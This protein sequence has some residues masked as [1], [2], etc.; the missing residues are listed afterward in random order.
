MPIK[1][2]LVD[3]HASFGESV[4]RALRTE[5]DLEISSCTAI[6]AAL[7][8][9]QRQPID[10]VL[11]DHD[12]GSERASQFL[13]AALRRGFSGRVVVVTAWI[14]DPEARL[15]LRQGVAGIFSKESSLDALVQSI[16]RVHAGEMW[17]DGRYRGLVEPGSAAQRQSGR[18]RALSERLR[19]VLR[20]VLDGLS[21][22]EIAANLRISESYVKALLQRLFKKTGVRT[23]AQLVRV[24]LERYRDQL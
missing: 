19:R 20:F 10:V 18:G 15:L 4:V 8:A 1:A 2:L 12:L 23:R 5:P 16:R 22:K 14:S 24:A 9:L 11:L 13:P 3:D 6:A 7:D 21:N 17:L